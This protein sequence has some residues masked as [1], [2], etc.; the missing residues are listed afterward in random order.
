MMQLRRAPATAAL[1]VAVALA[2]CQSMSDVKPGHGRK[3]TITGKS[4]NQIW[5]AAHKVVDEHLEIR[6]QDKARGVIVGERPMSFGSY[7]A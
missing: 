5:D 1:M 7:G 4:Y 6:E 2:A 3:A